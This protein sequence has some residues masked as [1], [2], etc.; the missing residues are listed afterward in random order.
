M[1]KLTVMFDL[2]FW[3]F[4]YGVLGLNAIIGI[5]IFVFMGFAYPYFYHDYKS[6]NLLRR[7]NLFTVVMEV[8]VGVFLP[9]FPLTLIKVKLID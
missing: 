6:G 4:I 9:L 5:Y 8:I 7:F 2:L 1:S 3:V